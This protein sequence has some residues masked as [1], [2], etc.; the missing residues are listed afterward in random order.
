MFSDQNDEPLRYAYATM[1]NKLP[2]DVNLFWQWNG[3]GY[4]TTIPANSKINLQMNINNEDAPREFSM[5]AQSAGNGERVMLNGQQKL[6]LRP[7]DDRSSTPVVLDTG[8]MTIANIQ[9]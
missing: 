2:R 3:I 1:H 5:T 4:I 7:S 8:K 6:V 9:I